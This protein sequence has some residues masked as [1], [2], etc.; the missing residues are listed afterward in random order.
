MIRTTRWPQ[1]WPQP[2]L[3]TLG[4]VSLSGWLVLAL[5]HAGL[6]M[7]ALC[8]SGSLPVTSLPESFELALLFNSPQRLVSGWAVM[9]AAM[10]L[11]LTVAALRHVRDRSLARRRCSAMLLFVAGHAAVWMLA[12]LVLQLV[13][14]SALWAM[15]A[16]RAWFAG[17][18]L[19]A[20]LWQ[21]SPVKQACLNGCHRRPQL[22]AFGVSASR[23]ALLFGLTD[24]AACVGACWALMLAMLLADPGAQL[25]A[26]AAL[27]LFV[28]AERLEAAAP[29]AWRWR[30]VGKALRI[31]RAR[32]D[33]L[34]CYLRVTTNSR[35]SRVSRSSS[36]LIE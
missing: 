23:D 8:V 30:G 28:F 33:D 2:W 17:A 34:C 14:I 5:G 22:M 18:V 12:G 32:A 3:I 21:V 15:P 11:P 36:V 16:P 1:P 25:P 35:I 7:P 24:G 29:L 31:I 27:A 6:V 4:V 13:A 26:M 9:W 10:M 20:L 19:L